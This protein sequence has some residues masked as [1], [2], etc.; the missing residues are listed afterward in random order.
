[1]KISSTWQRQICKKMYLKYWQASKDFKQ[2]N[3][4]R[5]FQDV[6][7]TPHSNH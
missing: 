2:R 1:M 5:K 3:Q 7:I 6:Y 4:W